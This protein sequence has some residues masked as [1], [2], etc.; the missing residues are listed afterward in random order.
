MVPRKKRVKNYVFSLEGGE[1][2]WII[3]NIAFFLPA[4]SN[5]FHSLTSQCHAL[6]RKW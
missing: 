1:K 2:N 5:G 6:N 3:T 4:Y